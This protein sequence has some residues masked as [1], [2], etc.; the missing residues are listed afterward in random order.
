MGAAN[1]KVRES[2]MKDWISLTKTQSFNFRTFLST[3]SQLLTWKKEG[4]PSDQLSMEN[5]IM[6]MNTIQTSLIIDPATQATDWLKI[7]LN[8]NKENV[9]VLNNQ[10]AKFNTQLEL[11]IRFGK[12]LIVLEADGIEGMLVP[13]LKKDFIQ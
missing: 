6:I 5:G 1:E 12:T 4:L 8:K 7:N 11:S 9:E 3:E 10:D 13:I 2:A